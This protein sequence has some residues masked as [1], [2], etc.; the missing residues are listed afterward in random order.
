MGNRDLT[1]DRQ[2]NSLI[3][4][5]PAQVEPV[6]LF[7]P[8]RL[9]PARQLLLEGDV[10]VRVGSRALEILVALVE[11]AGSVVTKQD[12]IA[13][14]WPRTVVEESNLKV[15]VAAL[16]R[17]LGEGRPGHRYLANVPGQGYRF[18][19]PVQCGDATV[20]VEQSQPPAT[21][22]LPHSATRVI[23][24]ADAVE[25][26]AEVLVERRFVSIVGPGGIG[27]TTVALAVAQA[28]ASQCEH[29][30]R[31]V[32]LAALPDGRFVPMAMAKVLGVTIQSDDATSALA[33]ALRDRSLV[34][35][36]DSCEHVLEAAAAMTD[37]ILAVA[38][39]VM[40][41]TTTREPLRARGE[42]VHRLAPLRSP[43]PADMLTAAQALA[44]PAI[45]L[46]VERACACLDDF[47]LSD[48]DAPVVAEICRKLEGMPLAIELTAT[49]VDAFALREL[50]GLLDNQIR[51]LNM[52]RRSALPRHR[53]LAAALDWSC[54]LLPE[55]E[56]AVLRRLSVFPGT[57]TLASACALGDR[58]ET[59]LALE[60][61]VA[62]SLVAA[63]VSGSMVRYRLLDTTRA[64]ASQKLVESGEASLFRRRHAEHCLEMLAQADDEP[65]S[66]GD[67]V[68]GVDNVRSALAWCH[69]D[70]GDHRL[71][72]ALT[73]AAVPLWTRLSLLDE[74][75]VN[76]E[77]ALSG[78]SQRQPLRDDERMKLCAALGVALLYTRGP[79]PEIE[80]LW[81]EALAIA[82]QA[83]DTSYQLRMLWGLPV[84]LVYI[85]AYRG[86]IGYLRRLK[87]IAREQGDWADQV[88]AERLVGTTLQYFGRH[89]S[90]RRRLENVLH[91]FDAPPR[92]SHFAR[93]QFDQRVAARVSLSNALWAQGLAG[94][95]MQAA[96]AAV[97]DAREVDHPLSLCNAIGN[98]AFP[99]ALYDGDFVAARQF[100]D[101][102]QLHLAQN[103][104]AVWRSLALGFEGI[105]LIAQGNA[106]GTP[107]LK[108]S[109]DSLFST[110]FQLRKSYYLC[111]LARGQVLSGDRMDAL[112]TLDE[113]LAWCESSGERWFL[114]EI[115]RIKGDLMLERRSSQG[116]LDA[117]RL[118]RQ[119]IEVAR[120]QGAAGWAL[121]TSLSLT[122]LYL[123]LDR[124]SDAIEVLT[125]HDAS[126]IEGC[127]A[128]DRERAH[129]L[130]EQLTLD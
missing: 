15:T 69:R 39:G 64:Y 45:E 102:L 73:I 47:S 127:S 34:I 67:P 56:R 122:D 42:T 85:G 20:D 50:S 89:A 55:I 92:H 71:G 124:T 97:E 31:F 32:D 130:R 79:R 59:V 96:R 18:V 43:S 128:A 74:C 48:A 61:L 84:Y 19:A 113:A 36:L 30:A 41:L 99:I 119:S 78:E 126:S 54:H 40:I 86:A 63:D 21:H 12:L 95:A 3:A 35:V 9:L 65:R 49:R 2:A 52:D 5:S 121:R 111:A 6:Y 62:K 117:E 93:F 125:R 25:T 29:G 107:K 91:A 112:L 4:F 87:R 8:F 105:F 76:V 81:T 60:Q 115:L 100:L 98:A 90:A 53:S 101:Q 1:P 37:A 27:K 103:A 13:R 129:L 108:R 46:F 38:P 114:P 51:L 57:F 116:Y 7:G 11:R 80:Q 88:S 68:R 16:R 77:K 66:W 26:V 23:G 33:T 118:Y 110:R 28:L 83:H 109:L 82:D 120:E 70:D 24:R 44:F 14:A 22:H 75:R 10:P 123:Q 17:S 72:I 94:P 104:L 58:Q 106:A